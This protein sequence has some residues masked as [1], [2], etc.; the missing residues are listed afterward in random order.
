MKKEELL[1]LSVVICFFGVLALVAFYEPRVSTPVPVCECREWLNKNQ[2]IKC[3]VR[4]DTRKYGQSGE[5]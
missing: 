5:M 3:I 4:R 1:Y 2:D